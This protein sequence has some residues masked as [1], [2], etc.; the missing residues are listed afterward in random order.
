MR[1]VILS[2]VH[3]WDDVRVFKK[4][5]VSLAKAG[6]DVVL[7]ARAEKK[8]CVDGVNIEPTFFSNKKNRFYRLFSVP[9]L[10]FKALGL[11]A[12][13]Y[14]LHNPDTLPLCIFLLLIRKKVIYDSHEDFEKRILARKWIPLLLRK[15]VSKFICFLERWVS[16]RAVA[17]IITQEGIKQRLGSGSRTVVIGNPPRV[18]IDLMQKVSILAKDITKDNDTYRAVYLGTISASR[19][20][21]EMIDALELLNKYIP[22]RLWLIGPAFNGNDLFRAQKKDGWQFVDYIPRINQEKAFAYLLNSDVGLITIKD[23]G[24]HAQTDPNKIYEYM[25]FGLP[26]VGS[27]FPLWRA[28]FEGFECGLFVDPTNPTEIALAMKEIVMNQSL[29]KSFSKNGID[30]VRTYN[31]DA[32]F[33]KLQKIYDDISC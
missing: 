10:I 30:Y 17:T 6:H 28:K 14:H 18:D 7:V 4:E 9:L 13:V 12:D 27:D 16:N 25:T 24:D 2:P 32:E 20:L 1:I 21:D 15:K 22:I 23:V 3:P 33:S 19:G 11:S 29:R 31:W 26:F 8:K 5:A